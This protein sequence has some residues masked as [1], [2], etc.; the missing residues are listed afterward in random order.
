MERNYDK[1]MLE[2]IQASEAW[3]HYL[4]GATYKVE[5]WTDH[6]NLRCFMSALKLNHCQ[7]WGALF[8]SCF[9][10]D[11]VHKSG[12]LMK[13]A[14]ALSRRPDYKRGVE[15]DNKDITLLKPEYF[16]IH[17]LHQ[18]HFLIDSS[19]K[20]MLSKIHNWT[21]MKEEVVKAINEMKGEKK[22][23]IRREEWAQEQGLILFRGK[24]YVPLN[25]ELQKEIVC[26]HHN[27]PISG[28]PS[29]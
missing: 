25:I 23:T 5:L 6:Q 22:K 24:V 19:E 15:D 10:F 26:L 13:K 8:L 7:A 18:G 16:R 2:T 17:A 9:D 3:R 14:N 12:S 29:Q 4:E 20:E 27:T 1:E 28:H 21:N 11:L